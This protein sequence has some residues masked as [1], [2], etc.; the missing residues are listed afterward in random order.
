MNPEIEFRERFHPDY[1]GLTVKELSFCRMPDFSNRDTEYL[2]DFITAEGSEDKQRPCVFFV[3]GGGFMQPCDKRQAYI[4]VFAKELAKAG[5]AVVSPDYPLYDNAGQLKQAGGQASAY[6]K[7]GE[8]VSK[9]VQYVREHCEELGV[10]P[11]R[12]A[13]MGGSA[14]GMAEFYAIA[15]HSDSY[16]AFINLWGV[17]DPLPDLSRFPPTLS[18]HGDQDRLVSYALE[19]PLQEQL[20]ALGIKHKLVTVKGADHTPVIRMDE[21]LPQIMDWLKQEL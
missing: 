10:D 3:H 2:L 13:L 1:T 4:P 16:R 8:A 7:A 12:I 17:P 19:C 20:E 21:F 18:V 11:S 14:G 5:Y 9:A 15:E 6:H